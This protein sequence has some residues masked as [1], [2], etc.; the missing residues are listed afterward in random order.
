MI[1]GYETF[2]NKRSLFVYKTFRNSTGYIIRKSN[3]KYIADCHP[4]IFTIFKKR[5]LFHY[6]HKIRNPLLAKKK[7]DI[8]HFDLRADYR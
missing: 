4:E 8:H 3:W 6:Y 7:L 2:Y 5:A 1:G